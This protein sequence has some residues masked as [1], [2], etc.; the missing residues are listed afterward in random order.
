MKIK[1]RRC[2]NCHTFFVPDKYNHHKQ[3]YCGESECRKVAAREKRAKYRQ[4]KK[5]DLEFRANEVKRVQQW[6][7]KNPGYSQRKS[8]IDDVR[9]TPAGSR[10]Q[11]LVLTSTSPEVDELRDLVI[12]QELILV[13][14][15]SQFVG[16]VPENIEAFIL[17]CCNAGRHFTGNSEFG[18][19][20]LSK[21]LAR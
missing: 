7:L 3:E 13:G 12:R 4:K 20:L 1:E 9:P 2:K 19:N 21:N 14:M 6:R 17:N 16:A 15:A 11:T 5:W 10:N 18:S 8:K